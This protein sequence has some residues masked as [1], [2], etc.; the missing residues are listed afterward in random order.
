M[1]LQVTKRWNE[2]L[3]KHVYCLERQDGSLLLPSEGIQ[4]YGFDSEE[5]AVVAMMQMARLQNGY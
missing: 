3:G 5:V 4:S 2:E 1:N